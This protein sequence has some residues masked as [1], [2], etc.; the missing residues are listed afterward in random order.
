MQEI[1]SIG[2]KREAYF[3]SSLKMHYLIVTS[4]PIIFHFTFSP[5]SLISLECSQVIA[6]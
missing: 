5:D 1:L 3:T 4:Q 6:A 2:D